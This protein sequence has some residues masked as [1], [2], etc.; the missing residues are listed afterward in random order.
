MSEPRTSCAK[1]GCCR[2][3]P[4]VAQ[5]LGCRAGQLTAGTPLH[6][7]ADA[8]AE[9]LEAEIGARD[10][11]LAVAAGKLAQMAGLMQQVD[12]L[13]KQ[14]SE[15]VAVDFVSVVQQRSAETVINR[16]HQAGQGVG[17]LP[18]AGADG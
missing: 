15:G 14:A 8:R 9:G 10:A 6:P 3:L 17:P 7:Q 18:Q 11:E 2:Q 13:N 4:R 5:R 1:L 16:V 12:A